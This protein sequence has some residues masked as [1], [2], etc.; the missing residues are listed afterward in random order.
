MKATEITESWKSLSGFIFDRV[1]GENKDIFTDEEYES[2]NIN[3]R[4]ILK[5][6]GNDLIVAQAKKIINLN[7]LDKNVSFDIFEKLPSVW[8]KYYSL[9]IDVVAAEN[10]Q[11]IMARNG[12]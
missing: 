1:S 9:S 4:K 8:K 11:Y 5:D 2:I 6:V 10:G 12:E 3:A 7:I